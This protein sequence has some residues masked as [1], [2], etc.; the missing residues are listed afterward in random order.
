[1]SLLA[2]SFSEDIST[3][4]FI[5]NDLSSFSK[6]II[7]ISFEVS[8]EFSLLS[9]IISFGVFSLSGTLKLLFN[10]TSV[11]LCLESLLLSSSPK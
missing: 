6:L 11:L 5:L 4:S 2:R 8:N 3:G 9:I 7:L 1:M 10:V